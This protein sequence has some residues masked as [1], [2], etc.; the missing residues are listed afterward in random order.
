MSLN[1]LHQTD[2]ACSRLSR[3]SRMLSNLE[4][5]FLT[6]GNEHLAGQMRDAAEDVD[7]S[8]REVKDAV[9]TQITNDSQQAQQATRNMVGAA[10]AGAKLTTVPPE[11]PPNR[12]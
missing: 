1:L 10:L 12:A 5:A 3:V 11:N 2:T 9:A 6:T 8:I 7:A 4:R